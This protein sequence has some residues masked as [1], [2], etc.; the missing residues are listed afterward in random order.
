M[1]W[2]FSTKVPSKYLGAARQQGFILITDYQALW[3]HM[4]H[5]E[6]NSSPPEQN[7]HH[8]ADDISKYIFV[9]EKFCILINISLKFVPKGQV[10]NIP[11]LV[12]IMAWCQIG[13]KP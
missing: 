4:G 10:N 6:F 2:T 12:Q 9:N 13:Y 5:N 8:F 3:H 7:G 1:S 11:A